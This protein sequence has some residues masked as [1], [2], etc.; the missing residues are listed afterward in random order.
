[1]TSTAGI[2]TPSPIPRGIANGVV[3]WDIVSPLEVEVDIGA[4]V[5]ENPLADR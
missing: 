2:P 4:T 5:T 3:V 1:M